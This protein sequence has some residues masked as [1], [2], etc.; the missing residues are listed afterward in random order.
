VQDRMGLRVKLRLQ[1]Q[2]IYDQ[3]SGLKS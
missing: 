3:A 2:D 1:I